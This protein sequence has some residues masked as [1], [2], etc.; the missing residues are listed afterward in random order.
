M[1]RKLDGQMLQIQR[2]TMRTVRRLNRKQAGE[3][4]RVLG[5]ASQLVQILLKDDRGRESLHA[6][7]KYRRQPQEE[8]T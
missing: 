2:R 8:Q 5:M 1:G 3:G 6:I 7:L 4:W